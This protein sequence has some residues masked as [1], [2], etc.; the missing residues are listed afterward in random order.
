MFSDDVLFEKVVLKGGNALDIVHGLGGRGSL[1]VDLSIEEDFDDVDDAKDRMF[2]ALRDRFDSAGYVVFDFGFGKK[3]PEPWAEN[4]EWGGYFAEFKIIEKTT[5]ERLA[6]DT[7]SLRRN[8]LLIG[9]GN[10]RKFRIEISKHEY[11]TG[12][13]K[14]ELDAYTIY[15]YSLP[16]IAAEKLRAICQQMKEYSLRLHP[17]PRARD[18][19][20]I[21][22]ILT[23]AKVDL[24]RPE[25]LEL[26]Q[27]MFAV[28]TVPLE[29][30]SRIGEYRVFHEIDWP[31]VVDSVPGG[32]RDFDYYFDYVLSKVK[33]LE[34][35]W[36]K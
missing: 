27:Q 36:V 23:R 21:H 9:P 14:V 33:E 35:L 6:S 10:K 13:Q 24:R 25:N 7:D 26:I 3:P 32:V 28:K 19:F 18:F 12:K 17:T 29:L 30:L 11:C 15:V 8:A 4:P 16:M 2:R 34:S 20:D 1:D 5:H 31:S 22:A